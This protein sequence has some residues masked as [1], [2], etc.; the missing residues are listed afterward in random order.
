M[1][2]AAFRIRARIRARSRSTTTSRFDAVSSA[3]S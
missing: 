3:A 2:I 1:T